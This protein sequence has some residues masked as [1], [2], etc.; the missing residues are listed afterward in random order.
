MT[1]AEKLGRIKARVAMIQEERRKPK[2]KRVIGLIGS[3][4][5]DI[6]SLLSEV[7]AIYTVKGKNTTGAQRRAG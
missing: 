2:R 5:N 4:L 3:C 7:N 6:E 1:D